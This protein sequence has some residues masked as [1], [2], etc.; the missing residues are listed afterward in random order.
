MESA[1]T[2]AT[3]PLL[4]IVDL[5]KYFGGLAAVNALNFYINK[6]EILALIGPNGAGKTTVF[7]LITGFLQP[8]HGR[9]LYNGEDVTGL[10]PHQKVKKGI[11]RSFQ[12]NILFMDKTVRENVLL[13]FHCQH[14]T[15]YLT[16]MLN[17]KRFIKECEELEEKA[18]QLLSFMHLY[19]LR[20]Q[21]AKNLTHGYQRML[22]MSVAL[23]ANPMLLLLDEPVSGM[24]A[25][26]T[27][28]IMG[29]IKKVKN[30][31]VT[32]LLV[33]HDMKAVMENC[34]R[35]VVMDHGSKIAEGSPSEIIKND[36]VIEAYLGTGGVDA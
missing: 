33:E 30:D 23:A 18:N 22:G 11:V 20:D 24:N 5:T 2:E 26:E 29:L 14:K 13:G 34:E 10:K 27:A 25:E 7:N 1:S 9:L 32:I 3:S 31:G 6:N 19:D 16:E 4:Q 8:I 15:G 36:K 28:L 17:L 35:I 21:Q 12:A